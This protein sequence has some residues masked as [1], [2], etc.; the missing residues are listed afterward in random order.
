LAGGTWNWGWATN[1]AIGSTVVLT[2]SVVNT[3][4]LSGDWAGMMWKS[5]TTDEND[6]GFDDFQFLGIPE[7]ST[8]LLLGVGGLLIWRRARSGK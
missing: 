1:S 6:F 2:E 8:M 7:P 5:S 3:A 4:V